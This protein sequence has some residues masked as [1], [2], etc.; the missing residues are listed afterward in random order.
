MPISYEYFYLREKMISF[1][2]STKHSKHYIKWLLACIVLYD[3][4]NKTNTNMEKITVYGLIKLIILGLW[5]VFQFLILS[6]V[7]VTF[8]NVYSGWLYLFWTLACS[9]CV[10]FEVFLAFLFFTGTVSELSVCC[11]RTIHNVA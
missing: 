10:C 2:V 4:N 11:K 7:F 6:T 5:N 1:G 9:I 8:I 3:N